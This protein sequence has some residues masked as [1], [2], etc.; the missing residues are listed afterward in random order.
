MQRLSKGFSFE[1]KYVLSG[2]DTKRYL[3]RITLPAD[4]W[5]IRYKQTEFEIIRRLR[6]DSPLIPDAHI[7]GTSGDESQCFMVLDFIE[8]T[9]GEV[10]LS[11]LCE[12][13]QYRIGVQAGK[14][15]KKMHALP[16]PQGLP[17]WYESFSAKFARKV[18]A[19]DKR[20]IDLPGIDREHLSGYIHENISCIRNSPRVFLHRDYHPANMV[21]DKGQLSGIIDFDRYEWG[22]P[23]FDFMALAYFS[24]AV[25]IPFSVGHID[26]YTGGLPSCEFWKRYALY[27]AMSIIPGHLWACDYAEKTGSPDEIGRSEKSI[28]MV[29][30]DLEGFTTDIPCWYRDYRRTL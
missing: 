18:A 6:K 4:P 21:I 14:E 13:D 19:F 9:D 29:C 1:E 27:C 20:G 12:T 17:D 26:G 16:A 25:S 2:N 30:A 28:Q 24:R 8:G 22:D 5:L 10:A 15:Q 7:F 23:V 11:G 3:L